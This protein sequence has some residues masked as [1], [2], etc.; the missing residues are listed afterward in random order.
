MPLNPAYVGRTF[1]PSAPYQV[2]RE[3]VREFA[4]AL[5]DANPAYHDV[6]VAR[7]L[8]YPDL[9]AP[10]TFGIVV[11]MRSLERLT[12]DPGLGLTWER[13]VHGEQRFVATRPIVAGDDLVVTTTI[14]KIAV[15]GGNDILDTRSQIT[16]SAGE[17]VVTA[18][19]RLVVRAP[20]E[21][22]GTAGGD[23][24]EAA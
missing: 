15:V 7:G 23:A 17:P 8:G 3:K 20:D 4:T 18:Y 6:D 19:A 22:G 24:T 2:G 1:P 12:E 16:T 9:L 21:P 11:T 5:G 14:E 10:P 13:V